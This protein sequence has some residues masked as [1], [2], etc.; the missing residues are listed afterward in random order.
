M[1]KLNYKYINASGLWCHASTRI[2]LEMV[3]ESK[4]TQ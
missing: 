1:R 4:M 2:K 3:P